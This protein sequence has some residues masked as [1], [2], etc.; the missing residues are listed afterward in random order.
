MCRV[1]VVQGEIRQ[2][3]GNLTYVKSY[4]ALNALVNTMFPTI[5]EESIDKPGTGSRYGTPVLV[6]ERFNDVNFWRVERPLIL[7][8]DEED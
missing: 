1:H 2:I 3:K 5:T 8:S 7:S 6:D 4:P